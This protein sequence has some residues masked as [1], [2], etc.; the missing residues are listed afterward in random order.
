[1]DKKLVA[2]L[3]KKLEPGIALNVVAHM[4]VGLGGILANRG[5]LE[6]L[7]LNDY[8]DADSKSHPSIS[9]YPF[10][11]LRAGM[12]QIKNV[13]TVASANGIACIHFLQTMTIGTYEQ[14]HQATR[15]T[16]N[17]DLEFLGVCMF[18]D[19]SLIEGLTRKFSLWK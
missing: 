7:R 14:Q 10:I 11:V 18:G 19:S 9:D 5:E 13:A 6:S 3:C 17:K 16:K 12:G 4:A 8:I 1:M 15:E 2:I